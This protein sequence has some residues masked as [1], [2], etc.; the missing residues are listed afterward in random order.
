MKKLNS[1]SKK[2]DSRNET[3]VERFKFWKKELT[4]NKSPLDP[5]FWGLLGEKVSK[6]VTCPI[7]L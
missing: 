1:L 3:M 6:T 4:G 2:G 5:C 7:F